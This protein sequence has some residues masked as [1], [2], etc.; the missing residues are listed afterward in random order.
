[1]L[2][3]P[4]A[5]PAWQFWRYK[6]PAI[7]LGCA[8]RA[9]QQ[10]LL[11]A[12]GGPPM[13]VLLRDS[14]GGAVLIGPWM[15]GLSLALPLGHPWL[16]R[17]LVDSYRPLG[18]LCAAALDEQALGVQ[19]LAPQDIPAIQAMFELRG[20]PALDWACFGKL[21]PWEVVDVQ[22]RKIVGLAQRRRQTGVLM[23]A[24]LLLEEPPWERLC[25]ALGHGEQSS[26]LPR[27]TGSVA[28]LGGGVAARERL[29]GVLQHALTRCLGDAERAEVTA[30][31]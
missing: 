28:A 17:G 8:Q 30:L 29:Q 1:M 27:R 21:S 3:Q 20:L 6:Q 7:V 18:Q 19:A 12:P 25:E 31:D 5:A 2:A 13:E 16:A 23:V 24:G 11:A 4:V 9:D 26:L 14:G 22:G 15:M 10:R